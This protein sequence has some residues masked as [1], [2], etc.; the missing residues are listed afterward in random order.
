MAGIK[1]HSYP[2]LVSYLHYSNAQKSAL[3]NEKAVVGQVITFNGSMMTWKKSLV[4]AT[5]SIKYNQVMSKTYNI[6]S[7]S[8]K[9]LIIMKI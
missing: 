9:V 2:Y 7:R 3:Y 1:M 5:L 6:R 8:I 4:I